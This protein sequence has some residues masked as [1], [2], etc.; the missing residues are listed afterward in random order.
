MYEIILLLS[1]V[2][3]V[4]VILFILFT[5]KG[6]ELLFGGTILEV[7]E[8]VKATKF[9]TETALKVIKIKKTDGSIRVGIEISMFKYG[10]F[11]ITPIV[12]SKLNAK[13]LSKQLTDVLKEDLN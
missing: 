5:R 9:G 10:N 13:L 6:K 11:Q 8:P 12:L 2:A 3:V 1:F 7:Y 4:L